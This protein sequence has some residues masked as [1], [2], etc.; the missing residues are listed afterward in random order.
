LTYR[1]EFEGQVQR[2]LVLQRAL[3]IRAA[4]TLVNETEVETG[5]LS[6]FDCAHG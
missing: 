3:L 1:F 4:Q 5:K 2:S 6:F